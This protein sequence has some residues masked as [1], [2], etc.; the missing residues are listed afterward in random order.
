MKE[1]T[2]LQTRAVS[3]ICPYCNY[4]NDGWVEDPRGKTDVCE[5]CEQEYKIHPD[6][7]IDYV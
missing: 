7:D 2:E 3:T 4:V 1:C 5:Q 6:A